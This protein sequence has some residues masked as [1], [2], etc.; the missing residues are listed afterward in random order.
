MKPHIG[1][2][3]GHGKGGWTV[4]TH[5]VQGGHKAAAEK[6]LEDYICGLIDADDHANISVELVG[7][8]SS[9]VA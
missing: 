8:E 9:A 2:H 7:T 4:L 3:L 6:F 5:A 1:T